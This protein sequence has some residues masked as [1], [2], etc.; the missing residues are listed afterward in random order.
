MINTCV[1]RKEAIFFMGAPNIDPKNKGP[2][3]DLCS[4]PPTTGYSPFSYKFLKSKKFKI[5]S[6]HRNMQDQHRDIATNSNS[7]DLCIRSSIL[8]LPANFILM[9]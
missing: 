6:F 9:V 7:I 3:V 1:E 8:I 2:S 5:I 4:L